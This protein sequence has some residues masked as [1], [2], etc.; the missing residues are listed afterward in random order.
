M[1]GLA[2]IIS[3][4]CRMC[5]AYASDADVLYSAG[6]QEGHRVRER[7]TSCVVMACWN[8]G[9]RL[10]VFTTRVPGSLKLRKFDYSV[11]AMNLRQCGKKC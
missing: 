4:R 3:L 11:L 2:E 10:C 6:Q 7:L 5:P 9:L 1:V 8:T